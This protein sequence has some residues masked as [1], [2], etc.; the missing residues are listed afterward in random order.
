M[1]LH[2]R[3]NLVALD[4][5]RGVLDCPVQLLVDY[6]HIV[7]ETPALN[8]KHV[9]CATERSDA[10]RPPGTSRASCIKF[11]LNFTCLADTKCHAINLVLSR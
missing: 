7:V 3:V 4:A 9:G 1:A 8:R 10:A 5:T 6:I 11:K 2:L